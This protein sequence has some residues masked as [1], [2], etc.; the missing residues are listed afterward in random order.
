M[1]VAEF[2]VRYDET[3]LICAFARHRRQLWWRGPYDVVRW[4]LAVVMGVL[5]GI[6]VYGGALIP[7]VILGGFTGALLGAILLGDPID[8]WLIK[9]RLRKSPFHNNDLVFRL[10][11]DEIHVVGNNE[12]THLKWSAFSK[13]RRF[14]DGLLM[15]QGPQFFNWLPD[16]GASN[17][18]TPAEARDLSRTRVKDYR[19]V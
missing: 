15:Y 13:A 18:E 7:A 14:P 3:Y 17:P 9:R 1:G 10:T 5:T 4:S 19:D 8:A 6:A 12:E 11:A 16:S 2:R